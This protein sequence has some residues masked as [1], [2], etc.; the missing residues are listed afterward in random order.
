MSRIKR[1]ATTQNGV[2]GYNVP[3]KDGGV[4]FV[5]ALEQDDRNQ[6]AFNAMLGGD[7]VAE[8]NDI[9]RGAGFEVRE[10][11]PSAYEV[12]E[13]HRKMWLWELTKYDDI[14]LVREI[15]SRG[16]DVRKAA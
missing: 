1:A 8:L 13:A 11:E 15:E 3:N 16:Y 2:T 5:P 4:T 6:E 12:E 9:F 10:P 14:D 7:P